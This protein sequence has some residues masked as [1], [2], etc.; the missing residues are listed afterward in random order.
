MAAVK[1]RLKSLKVSLL[2]TP[3]RG[4]E[5]TE[6]EAKLRILAEWRIWVGHQQ[7]ADSHTLT[8]AARFFAEIAQNQPDLLS[9]EGPTDKWVFVKTALIHAGLIKE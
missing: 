7:A 1:G 6:G 5:M 8:E 2:R 4:E 9:F 3:F